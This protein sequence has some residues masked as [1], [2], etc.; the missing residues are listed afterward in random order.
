MNQRPTFAELL[1][2]SRE[3]R[4]LPREPRPVV[5]AKPFP[6]DPEERNRVIREAARRVIERHRDELERLADM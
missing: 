5:K 6:V 2:A 3:G 4:S 1:Q